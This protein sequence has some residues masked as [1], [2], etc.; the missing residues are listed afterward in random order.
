MC[1]FFTMTLRIGFKIH[2]YLGQNKFKFLVHV[3]HPL[4]QLK[5]SS[6]TNLAQKKYSNTRRT[7]VSYRER[8][9]QV[10]DYEMDTAILQKYWC[11]NLWKLYTSFSWRV[12]K[13]FHFQ[14]TSKWNYL[15]SLK[16]ISC[17]LGQTVY[18]HCSCILYLLRL[19]TCSEGFYWAGRHNVLKGQNLSLKCIVC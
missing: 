19:S 15:A 11:F 3:I 10:A 6:H 17:L 2:G 16:A 4:P 5:S 13:H 9:L 8:D 7:A 12:W 14:F 1:V 18:R